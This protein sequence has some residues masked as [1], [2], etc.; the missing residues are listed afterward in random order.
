MPR[1]R[2][3]P[4]KRRTEI[5]EPRSKT[6]RKPSYEYRE[7]D[8]KYERP[9]GVDRNRDYSSRYA[10]VPGQRR[11]EGDYSQQRGVADNY[12]GQGYYGGQIDTG[13][14]GFRQQL[15][16]RHVVRKRSTGG[17]DLDGVLE[18]RETREGRQR[19]RLD[20]DV[21]GA[22]TLQKVISTGTRETQQP[23]LDQTFDDIILINFDDT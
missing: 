20:V 6:P 17:E 14:R 7:S 3:W 12:G 19:S 13:K 22:G 18:G 5:Q 4:P 1:F 9:H 21:P 11:S 2:D 16:D 8:Q 15:N 10:N 23:R